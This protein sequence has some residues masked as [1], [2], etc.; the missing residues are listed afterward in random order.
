MICLH[1]PYCPW[2]YDHASICSREYATLLYLLPE[3]EEL[4]WD[5]GDAELDGAESKLGYSRMTTAR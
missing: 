5:V 1:S 4:R 3:S 2:N